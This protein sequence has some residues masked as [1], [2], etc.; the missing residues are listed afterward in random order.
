LKQV[1]C[2]ET[3]AARPCHAVHL[4]SLTTGE[5]KSVTGS[6]SCRSECLLKSFF[7]SFSML[8]TRHSLNALA[9][10]LPKH[11]RVFVSAS[12]L[13]IEVEV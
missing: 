12:N 3:A 2:A 6:A 5:L 11:E 4:Y 7:L 8:C 1:C 10:A 13:E 9:A